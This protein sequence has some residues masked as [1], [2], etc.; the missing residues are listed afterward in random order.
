MSMMRTNQADLQ[1]IEFVDKIVGIMLLEHSM[2]I[3]RL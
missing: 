2:K 3:N 1:D